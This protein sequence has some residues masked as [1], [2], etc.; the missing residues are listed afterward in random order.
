LLARA[1]RLATLG[2]RTF[3][4]RE[5]NF[6]AYLADVLAEARRAMKQY[7]LLV[8]P[9]AEITQNTLRSRKNAHIIALTTPYAR[10]LPIGARGG[11]PEDRNL[12]ARRRHRSL[13]QRSKVKGQR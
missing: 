3:G 11:R 7:G 2:R 13:G 8:V 4:V 12:V 6:D 9:G 10:E 1:G 5:E